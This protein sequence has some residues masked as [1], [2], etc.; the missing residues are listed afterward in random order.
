ML[1]TPSTIGWYGDRRYQYVVA[2]RAVE[3]IDSMTAQ[4]TSAL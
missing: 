4:G 3:T 2:L 1:I